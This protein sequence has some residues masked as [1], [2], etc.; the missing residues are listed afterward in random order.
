MATAGGGKIRSKRQHGAGK[1]YARNKGLLGRVTDNVKNLIPS[2]LQSYFRTENSAEAAPSTSSA[3][4]RSP[5]SS[6]DPKEERP[7]PLDGFSFAGLNHDAQQNCEVAGDGAK[8]STSTAATSG[9]T[10]PFPRTR[11]PQKRQPI[12]HSDAIEHSSLA[13]QSWLPAAGNAAG[14]KPGDARDVAATGREAGVGSGSPSAVATGTRS[15]QTMPVPSGAD[16]V[17][18]DV[19]DS[20]SQCEDDS[21]S[22]TSGFSS[23]AS[24]KDVSMQPRGSA[25]LL[26]P[27]WCM[28][29]ELPA[30]ST[31]QP[32]A[33]SAKKPSFN[34][35]V[36]ESSRTAGGLGSSQR[37]ES[38]FYAGKTTYGGASAMSRPSQR[39]LPVAPYQAPYRVQ[40]KAKPATP[41]L[42]SA[43]TSVTAR[44]ILQSLEKLS[45]PLSDAL[46]IPSSNT[47]PSLSGLSYLDPVSSLRAHRLQPQRPPVQQLVTPRTAAVSSSRSLYRRSWAGPSRTASPSPS[48]ATTAVTQ[49]SLAIDSTQP[50]TSCDNRTLQSSKASLSGPP[51]ALAELATPVANGLPRGGGGGGG[52]GKMKRE[53]IAVHF[54]AQKDDE[55]ESDV[56]LPSVPLPI[57]AGA[58]PS[59]SFGPVATSTPA[60]TRSPALAGTAAIGSSSST[61]AGGG[62]GGGSGSTDKIPFA[63]TTPPVKATEFEQPP[64]SQPPPFQFSTPV[65]KAGLV[66]T[67]TTLPSSGTGFA[68]RLP[69]A[70]QST[71]VPSVGVVAAAAA[72]SGHKERGGGTTSPAGDLKGSKGMSKRS[73][74]E[75]NGS[76][77]G[78]FK[79][80]KTLK[81]GSVLDILK[82]SSAPKGPGISEAAAS[83]GSGGEV[84]PTASG[85]G[86]RFRPPEGSWECNACMVQ[87]Q[88]SHVTCVACQASKPAPKRATAPSSIPAANAKPP[89]VAGPS[90]AEQFA[91]PPGSWDCDTCM[92]SNRGESSRCVAC[93][94][95][96]AN[97]AP[98]RSALA[99]PPSSSS[100]SSAASTFFS[101]G[102]STAPASTTKVP[103]SVPP[104]AYAKPSAAAASSLASL[105]V[106]P[107]GAWDCD[108]CMVQNKAGSGSC[109]ACQTAKPGGKAPMS[110]AAP[111]ATPVGFGDKFKRPA[112]SWD[113][114]TCMVSNP[115]ST[116]VCACCSTERPGAARPTAQAPAQPDQPAF[117]FGLSSDD[118]AASALPSAAATFSFNSQGGFKFGTGSTSASK[119]TTTTTT[120]TPSSAAGASGV[121]DTSGPAAAR[122]FTFGTTAPANDSTVTFG[123]GIGGFKL[124]SSDATETA[125]TSAA[126]FTFGAKVGAGNSTASAAATTDSSAAATSTAKTAEPKGSSGGTFQFGV[127]TPSFGQNA[128]S[129]GADA[130]KPGA[131]FAFA[132]DKEVAPATFGGFQFK[133]SGAAEQPAA[134]ATFGAFGGVK[135]SAD[136]AGP[137]GKAVPPLATGFS[138]SKEAAQKTDAD[139]P[140]AKKPFGFAT[141]NPSAAATPGLFGATAPAPASSAAAPASGS[142]FSFGTKP[143]AFGVPVKPDAPAANAGPSASIGAAPPFMF[144]PAASVPAAKP[145]PATGAAPACSSAQIAPF[146]FAPSS[147]LDKPTTTFLFGP[148]H[149]SQQQ[150]AGTAANNSATP[151]APFVFGKTDAAVTN[152][153]A[154]NAAAAPPVFGAVPKTDAPAANSG[155][156][157]APGSGG[158]TFMFGPSAG[159]AASAATAAV[160]P[161]GFGGVTGAAS[162]SGA[163]FGSGS[164]SIF[165]APGSSLPTF[166]TA[167]SAPP[168]GAAHAFGTQPSG[169]GG[170]GGGS[171]DGGGGPGG[172]PF[173]Q[174]PPTQP[175]AFGSSGP[176][177]LAP[178]AFGFSANQQQAPAFGSGAAPAGGQ[179][180]LFSAAVQ[181][182]AFGPGGAAGQ[183]AGSGSFQF[184]GAAPAQGFNFGGA[185]PA[186]GPSG[187]LTFGGSP[188]QAPGTFQFNARPGFN[189][190][191][192]GSPAN[193]F[194]GSSSA[195]LKNRKYKT[196]VRRRK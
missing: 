152:A 187:S 76:G 159:S 188:Q 134:T 196:A 56:A 2:W 107:E 183:P 105:F 92:V 40:V 83:G 109:V 5:S 9:H 60:N 155:V 133:T 135:R 128:L 26:Q 99:P 126:T 59:F 6:L 127:A 27:L 7:A 91:A 131:G 21:V 25:V 192:S 195:T 112:G 172:A 49:S 170:G 106:R 11:G 69:S 72:L 122:G 191:M 158:S 179:Q 129:G 43:V 94:T 141:M 147:K 67:P 130:S 143:I 169:G 53:R 48:T 181:K 75:D 35:T 132:P 68:F 82:A 103:A 184:A 63:F 96:R 14:P 20:S 39:K 61:G 51:K 1:P 50:G 15:G 136:G 73:N 175:P 185:S 156:A 18:R 66:T 182:P 32:S 57:R 110:S 119:D 97:L 37:G 138:F 54:S 17:A 190:G 177:Q 45:S 93:D 174:Q 194:Q 88:A 116:D 30:R 144:G 125:Q 153:T 28:G 186:P 157:G 95:P 87:N 90:L 41:R 31:P 120:T 102:V 178:P 10:M 70:T 164:G 42:T 173:R 100:S 118:S 86:D 23:R 38:T 149:E 171:G 77:G 154:T 79:A 193:Q 29:P 19:R 47:S 13:L 142:S 16:G 55:S 121:T 137:E 176:S 36:F 33:H 85:F 113:C 117:S 123:G 108:V 189:I 22:T 150:L 148:G 124:P 3:P 160:T 46:K 84:R 52:G 44:R 165:S 115:A 64:T 140:T 12:R 139:E 71:P 114:D 65:T 34:L 162:S 101:T 111:A 4:S 8:P 24:D 166:G 80:A 98:K 151:V 74:D 104:P 58:L 180:P 146:G 81:S 62:G 78:P 89:Q 167:S 168:A 163:G 145:D 161:F